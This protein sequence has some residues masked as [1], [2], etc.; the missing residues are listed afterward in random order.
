[1]SLNRKL[2]HNTLAQFVGKA[3]GT[4][5]ALLATTQILRYLGPTEY[6]K[7]HIIL[8]VVQVTGIVAD[9]GLYLIVLNDI[10][11]PSRDHKHVMSQHFVFRVYLNG[12]YLAAMAAL[13]F[14]LPYESVIRWGIAL[15][16][17]SNS[18]NWFGQIFQSFF[19]KKFITH[20]GA[21]AEIAGRGAL[22]ASTFI[23][24]RAEASLLL[25]TLTVV[26][27]SFVS[28]VFSWY[29]AKDHLALRWKLDTAYIKDVLSRTWPVA[30]SI[31]FN[32]LYF[33][34]DTII[35]SF[36]VSD[37]D[38]GIYGMP[39]R[40]LETLVTFPLLFM[41]LIMPLLSDA[42]VKKDGRSFARYMQKGFDGLSI[43]ALP[44][45]FGTMLLAREIVVLLAGEEFLPSALV[46]RILI[47][48]VFM[49]FIGALFAHAV[50]TIDKQRAM[51]K[52]YA[53]VS[54]ASF[55]LY[56]IFIPIYSYKAA[57]WLTTIGEVFI[58]VISF[59]VVYKKTH[60]IPRFRVFGKAL[61]S[62]ILMAGALYPLRS[63]SVFIT[64]PV[65]FVVYGGVLYGIG[66]VRKEVIGEILKLKTKG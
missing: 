48:G 50:I 32:L 36:Y 6:G 30:I 35:L 5:L 13:S 51:I 17:I 14:A 55:I 3:L 26:I 42:H 49:M 1:M 37:Y 63:F 62:A 59:M 31:W 27:G 47:I 9:F 8:T 7:F 54:V 56:V 58:L 60:F 33:K 44:I 38:V 39:Y 18:F 46:L 12:I 2:A 20:Y 4:L 11:H 53:V 45:L 10:S 19:Q 41:G 64:F 24:I 21:I 16:A 57:A 22:L 34:A 25:L 23:M 65:A 29:Y 40:I 52:H 61:V 15:M 28:F 43:I 66:G